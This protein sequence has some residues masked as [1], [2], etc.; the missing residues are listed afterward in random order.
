MAQKFAAPARGA[1]VY[2]IQNGAKCEIFY[3]TSVGLILLTETAILDYV[4]VCEELGDIQYFFLFRPCVLC[5]LLETL[6]K[7]SEEPQSVGVREA[8]A[9][10]HYGLSTMS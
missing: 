9:E 3:G 1:V 2:E 7:S 4:L 8:V 6:S 10:V 5:D